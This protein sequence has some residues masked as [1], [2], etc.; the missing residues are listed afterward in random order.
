MMFKARCKFGCI[1]LRCDTEVGFWVHKSEFI[2]VGYWDGVLCAG[3]E[4]KWIDISETLKFR[5][6][7]M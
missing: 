5:E 1:G 2:F 3:I 7:V 4:S 6:H